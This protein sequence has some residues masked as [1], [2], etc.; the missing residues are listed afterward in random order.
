MGGQE[1]VREEAGWGEG[2]GEGRVKQQ[3]KHKQQF[4]L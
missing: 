1:G 4:S 3:F 2:A